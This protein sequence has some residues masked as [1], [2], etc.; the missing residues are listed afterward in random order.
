MP[1]DGTWYL[2]YAWTRQYNPEWSDPVVEVEIKLFK[3]SNQIVLNPSIAAI[4][5]N[6]AAG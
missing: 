4:V 6:F 2:V 1:D 5:L 3:S